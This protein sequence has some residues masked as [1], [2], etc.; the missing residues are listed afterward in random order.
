[1]RLELALLSLLLM[2]CPAA[3]PPSEA[4]G[5]RTVQVTCA[6][7]VTRVY[8]DTITLRGTLAPLPARD[9]LV[10]A[11]V[12][13]AI[14]DVTVREGDTVTVGQVVA[15][16]DDS[17]LSDAARQAKATLASAA[18][19]RKNA[20]TSLARSRQ[21]FAAGVAPRQ[22]VDDAVAHLASASAA[23]DS[24]RVALDAATR[25]VT[26]ATVTSPIAGVVLRVLE[27]PG[28][29]VDGTA[30]A[31][32]VE[33]ADTSEL[34]LVANVAAADLTRLA[35]G[36]VA[37][38]TFAGHDA[39]YE[40]AVSAVAPAIDSTTGFGTLRIALAGVSGPPIGSY[41]SAT[42][43]VGEPRHRLLVPATALR[44]PLS[45]EAEV[46]VCGADH[47]AHVV[48]VK[49][50]PAIDDLVE[51]DG[52]LSPDAKIVIDAV[53]GVADGDTLDERAG[54]DTLAP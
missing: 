53:L 16:I 8:P 1:M 45:G 33:I 14:R 26:R 24:A 22:E 10:A 7:I 31:P 51:V 50:G 39:P 35:R 38:I 28:E 2:A 18:A 46:V 25:D 9:M 52:T 40:G 5:P 42:I 37:S 20:Q 6:A 15:H 32:I 49:L 17:R 34:E 19:E 13:G 3:A 12:A 21:V 23:E 27:K 41:G 29:L 11:Q 4:E 48:R 47:V 30:A 44:A 43:G 54:P 36:Q